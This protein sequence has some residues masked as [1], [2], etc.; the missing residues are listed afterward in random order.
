MTRF[1]GFI[2]ASLTVGATLTAGAAV[3]QAAA[4]F[5]DEADQAYAELLWRA[6][7]AEDLVG[8]D[9]IMAFPYPG[10][11]PHGIML[12]TFYTTATIDSYEGTLVVKRNYG[13]A[14]VTVDEVIGDPAGHLAAITVMFQR[15]EGY[16]IETNDWFYAKYLPDGSLDS[17]PAG[18]ALAGLVGKGGDAGCIACHQ[19][20]G[21]GDYLFTTDAD[22]PAMH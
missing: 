5:G 12:E 17:N 19:G 4:P 1:H 13:P 21:G 11:D 3:S 10:T 20:A 22:L 7:E 14:G 9:S 8:A 18:I 15:A 2:C 6:M 16:D